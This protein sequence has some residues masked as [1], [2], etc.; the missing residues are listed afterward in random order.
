M[1]GQQNIKIREYV[2][3]FDLECLSSRL[4]S[5]SGRFRTQQNKY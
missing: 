5:K 2:L 4:P 1:H 3:S